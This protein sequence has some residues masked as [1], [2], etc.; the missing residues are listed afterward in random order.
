[1][2]SGSASAATAPAKA[3][4]GADVSPDEIERAMAALFPLSIE[5]GG[6]AARRVFDESEVQKIAR[7]LELAG[8]RVWGLRPRTYAILRMINKLDV[9]D[10]FIA[11][12]LRDIS[13]PYSEKTLPEVIDNPS[14]R[15][16]FLELQNL[17]LTATAQAADLE[18]DGGR[19]RHFAHSGDKHF[20]SI[21]LL[22]VGGF[23][24]VDHVRSRL[25]LD[26]FARKRM[27]RGRTFK[28]DK[29]AILNF[30]RE[31][32]ALK[33]LSHHHLVK[34]V[35]SYTDPKFV[36][37]IMSPVA[38]CNLGQ[39]LRVQP[40]PTARRTSLQRFYGCLSSALLYL[41]DH[42]IRH[43]DIKPGNI[44]VHGENVLLADFG[45]SLDW[46]NQGESTTAGVP[47]A[48]SIPYCA[49]EVMEWEVS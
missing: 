24:E 42:K 32:A 11:E 5:D 12:G 15:S 8:K 33:R 46:T 7:L 34:L 4:P 22:G 45:T 28:K 49:P 27:P 19:H 47:S 26:E 44:L 35:G 10:Y 17:V 30:E 21:K 2:I 41:H 29:A 43:K 36:G 40:F 23:G 39:F 25:S 48:I 14:S 1:M 6:P 31:L 37:L 9:M 13:F 16:K 3:L 20:E 38:D 18:R